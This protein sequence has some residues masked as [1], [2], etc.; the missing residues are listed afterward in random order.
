MGGKVIVLLEDLAEGSVQVLILSSQ[1]HVV[2]ALK[3][4]APLTEIKVNGGLDFTP[5]KST[6]ERRKKRRK[7]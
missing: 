1:Q 7:K 4:E 3:E 2:D 6:N 5:G